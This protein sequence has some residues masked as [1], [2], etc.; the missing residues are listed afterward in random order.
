MPEPPSIRVQRTVEAPVEVVFRAFTDP[1]EA[2]K[3]WGPLGISTSVVEI[4]LR[5]G[6]LC[7][8][9]MHPRGG[10]AVLRGQIVELDPPY[11]LVMTNQWEGD[12]TETLV[13]I[14]FQQEGSGTRLDLSHQRLPLSIDPGEFELG[15]TAALDSLQT[16]LSERSPH[17]H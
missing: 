1:I 13:S 9:V 2:V 5:V 6:G 10:T 4:D 7:R 11:L 16:Y 12:P 3:W 17:D 8:W 15:W 14:R